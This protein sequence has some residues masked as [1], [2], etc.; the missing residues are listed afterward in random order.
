M[1]TSKA[2]NKLKAIL[3]DLGIP[4]ES[5]HDDTLL[6]RDLQLDSTEIVEI[7]LGLKQ[8]LGIK[9]KLGGRKDLT[10]AQVC[11]RIEAEMLTQSQSSHVS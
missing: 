3:I 5:L 11:D 9:V 4:R 1:N 6:H 7:V 10:L 2:M 8:N